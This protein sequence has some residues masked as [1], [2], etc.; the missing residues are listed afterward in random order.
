MC[1][2]R[3]RRIATHASPAAGAA[4]SDAIAASPSSN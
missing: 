4:G 2:Q 3:W 1:R